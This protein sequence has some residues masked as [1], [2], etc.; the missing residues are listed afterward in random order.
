MNSIQT[1]T[2]F[3]GWCTV[4]DVGLVFLALLLFTIF[5][6]GIGTLTVR[7]LVSPAKKRRQLFS[8]LSCSSESRLQSLTLSRI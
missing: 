3:F 5:H 2:T 6:D 1:L 8:A 4:L 7:C